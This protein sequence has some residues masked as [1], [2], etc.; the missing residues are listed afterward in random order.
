MISP[1]LNFFPDKDHPIEIMRHLTRPMLLV[2]GTVC[3]ISLSLLAF[4]IPVFESEEVSGSFFQSIAACVLSSL[5]AFAGGL[6]AGVFALA[7]LRRIPLLGR[8]FPR[9]P[10]EELKEL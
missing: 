7:I 4:G 10:T 9:W 1:W 3:V 8:C 6:A 2:S 5:G